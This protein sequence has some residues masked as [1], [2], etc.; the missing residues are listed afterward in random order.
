MPFSLPGGFYPTYTWLTSSAITLNF[1]LHAGRLPSRPL[2]SP[3][4]YHSLCLSPPIPLDYELCPWL[5]PG[6]QSALNNVL[7][8]E[9]SDPRRLAGRFSDSLGPQSCPLWFLLHTGLHSERPGKLL[10]KP[11][12][13]HTSPQGHPLTHP[14]TLHSAMNPALLL[15]LCFL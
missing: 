3:T 8:K 14:Q 7:A 4:C 1:T 5:V 9:C 10:R 11:F 2:C 12:P 6:I 15:E 13:D